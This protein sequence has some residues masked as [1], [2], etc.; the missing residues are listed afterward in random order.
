[1]NVTTESDFIGIES[2]GV[3]AEHFTLLNFSNGGMSAIPKNFFVNWLDTEPA[4]GTFH[5]GRACWIGTGSTV[6]YDTD[7][8]CLRLGSYI[9]GGQ[10]L[11]FILNGQHNA[12][13]ASMF[14]FSLLDASLPGTAVP[15][16]GDTVV[17]ND[18]W[19]GD[20][21]MILGGSTIE[22]GC[23]IGARALLPQNFSSEPYG[24]YVG[25]PAKLKKFRFSEPVRERLL[26]LAWWEMPLS[27]IKQNHAH[28]HFD[29][30]R[31]EGRT[32]EVLDELLRQKQSLQIPG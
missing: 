4:F 2:N 1:M 17:K 19:I 20:E 31:D 6:K 24:V 12:H 27:W 25:T 13:F 32:L 3:L 5:I 21:A 7:Q 9:A 11:R 29:L 8:Q 28:F 15:Q 22:N 10:R 23:I 18:V 26:Q 16:C 14:Y 30:N